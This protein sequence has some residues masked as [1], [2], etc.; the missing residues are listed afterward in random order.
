MERM[1]LHIGGRT[2]IA[3]APKESTDLPIII[4][5]DGP[6]YENPGRV[7]YVLE[8]LVEAGTCR[9]AV[10]VLVPPIDRMLEYGDDWRAYGDYIFMD[11]LPTVRRRTDASARAEDTFMGGSSLGGLI[12]LRLAEEFPD[13]LAGGIQCQ[14]AAVQWA[15][16][17]IEHNEAVTPDKLKRISPSCRIWLDWGDFEDTLTAANQKL[18]TTLRGQHRAFGFKTTSEGHTWTAW[19]NR[20]EAGLTY[21]L[22]AKLKTER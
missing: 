16:L 17:A 18:A 15:A 13:K 11:L 21:L 9:P 2:V 1:E 20:M 10:V 7:Q 6:S 5:G 4:Y 8:N 14:S 19:R 12:S 3:F 22:P